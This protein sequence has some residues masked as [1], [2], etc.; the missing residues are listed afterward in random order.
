L[1]EQSKF[2]G[3][4]EQIPK[5]KS[6]NTFSEDEGCTPGGRHIIRGHRHV[7]KGWKDK[8]TN[9]CSDVCGWVLSYPYGKKQSKENI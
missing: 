1:T 2:A 8:Q 7:A 4:V 3:T 9:A 6:E 5:S